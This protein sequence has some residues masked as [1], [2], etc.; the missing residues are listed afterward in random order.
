MNPWQNGKPVVVPVA[1]TTRQH[2]REDH[3]AGTK[4]KAPVKKGKV[5]VYSCLY[6]M[7]TSKIPLKRLY[8]TF[9]LLCAVIGPSQ[10]QD[11]LLSKSDIIKLNF[12]SVAENKATLRANDPAYRQ[13]LIDADRLLDFAPVSVMQ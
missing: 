1:P 6:L 5:C 4:K 13:L 7:I 12:K 3:S 10:A 9:C 8:I 2:P 11:S